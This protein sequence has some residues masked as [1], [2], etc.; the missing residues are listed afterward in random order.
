M[1]VPNL[2]DYK[3]FLKRIFQKILQQMNGRNEWL[4]VSFFIL[5]LDYSNQLLQYQTN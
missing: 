2:L 4:D 1:Y 3:I 5:L